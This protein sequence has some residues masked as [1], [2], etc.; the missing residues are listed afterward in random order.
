MVLSHVK[1][2]RSF[3]EVQSTGFCDAGAVAAH[4]IWGVIAVIAAAPDKCITQRS[5]THVTSTATRAINA[6]LRISSTKM[7]GKTV[8]IPNAPRKMRYVSTS[9][10]R[11]VSGASAPMLS[12]ATIHMTE[13]KTIKSAKAT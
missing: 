1:A 3:A 2:N 9:G 5:A 11:G 6:F 12:A 8:T 7:T 4:V 13:L 10:Q